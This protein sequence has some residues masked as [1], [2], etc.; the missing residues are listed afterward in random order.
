[1]ADSSGDL[2]EVLFVGM[3]GSISIV[4]RRSLDL[5][6]YGDYGRHA[7]PDELVAM[8]PEMSAYARVTP[9]EFRPIHSTGIS[10]SDWLEL[11][12][13]INTAPS[14]ATGLVLTHG[15]AS[16]EETAYFLSL[17]VRIAQPVVLVGA[18]R[19]PSALSSDSGLNLVN[20]VRVA[21]DPSTRSIGVVVVANDEIHAARDVTKTD[22]YRLHTFRTP[23]YGALGVVDPDRVV[24]RRVAT[25]PQA[26][27]GPFDA[28]TLADLPRCD[29]VYSHAGADGEAVD[30]AV[31][32]GCAAIVVA[33]MAPGKPT[34]GETAAIE[35]AV[36]AGVH[37]IL[38][39]RA[40]SGRVLSMDRTRAQ[41]LT[42]AD[43]LS[44]QKAR[45]L[46]MLALGVGADATQLQHYMVTC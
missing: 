36:S 33:T 2:P 13:L 14:S 9:R 35:R 11:A 27:E 22:T 18:Q 24:V 17:T 40:G 28:S 1:M 45:I 29:I 34:P 32:A 41:K 31:K 21:A 4:G 19:P 39:C 37:V 46:A 38:S 44:P 20:A 7:G 5:A 3:G 15:T 12:R 10:A 8:Y 25:T 23:V 16:L 6:E 30:A 43:D 42:V 26:P